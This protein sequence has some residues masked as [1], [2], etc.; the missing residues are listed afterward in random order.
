MEPSVHPSEGSLAHVV[1][2]PDPA[3]D[4]LEYELYVSD[5][6]GETTS[7]GRGAR[8]PRW[9]PD[10]SRLAYAKRTDDGWVPGCHDLALGEVDWPAPPGELL[11]LSWAPDGTRLLAITSVAESDDSEN[12]PYRVESSSDWNPAHRTC[13]WVIEQGA[14]PARLGADLGDIIAADFAPDGQ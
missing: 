11:H 2:G 7:L 13:A 10:G 1:S 14:D 9:S 3:I 8:S 5:L 6:T 4:G 12:L